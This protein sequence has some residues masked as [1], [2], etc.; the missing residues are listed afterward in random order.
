MP[1][2]SVSLSLA[3]SVCLYARPPHE[4]PF[5]CSLLTLSN[6][7]G[8]CFHIAYSWGVRKLK[9]VYASLGFSGHEALGLRGFDGEREGEEEMLASAGVAARFEGF[10]RV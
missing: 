2:A 7:S 9:R 8:C 3:V 4:T 6:P 5:S 1:L 10:M